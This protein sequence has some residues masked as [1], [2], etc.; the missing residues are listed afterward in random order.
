M[1]RSKKMLAVW[2]AAAVLSALAVAQQQE[3]PHR[4]QTGVEAAVPDRHQHSVPDEPGFL[5]P[6]S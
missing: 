3:P 2:V 6:L 4:H 1:R 5:A